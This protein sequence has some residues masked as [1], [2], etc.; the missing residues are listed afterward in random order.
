MPPL[1]IMIKP[2]S[3]NCNMR[4]LYCFYADEASQRSISSFGFMPP[5][6][7][8][9]IVRKALAK[10][11]YH[12]TFAFQGGEPTLAGLDFYKKLLALEKKYN[13][14]KISIKNIIQTNGYLIDE[15]WVRFFKKR[16]F[17]IGLSID[18]PQTIHDKYRKTP[19]K[20]GTF[21]RIMHTVSLLKKYD[22]EF[23]V[24]T[25]VTSEIA[26]QP[27]KVY[28]FYRNQ[29]LNFQQY[30]PC[31][32]PLGSPSEV[33]DYTLTSELYADFLTNMFDLWYQDFKNGRIIYI[34]FFENLLGIL[35]GQP[36]NSCTLCP[37]CQKQYVIEADGSVYPCDFY[38]LDHYK[39]GNITADTF[40][41]LD[42]KREQLRFIDSSR[43]RPITCNHC[44]WYTL[45]TSGCRRERDT[46]GNILSTNIFCSAYKQF[47]N[48]S[49]SRLL[50]LS[51]N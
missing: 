50:E 28:H 3:S 33:F 48:Y 42:L 23:N 41:S 29:N 22:V 7:L 45:C 14:K 19:F 20:A 37:E 49:F 4:C 44:K 32:N 1:T 12:C 17:F 38:A 15:T 5:D 24:L 2:A 16:D 40:A 10:A 47:F 43:I 26:K 27:S 21:Q 51:R 8:D 31:L 9:E 30:I 18:G 39:L 13:T 35:K 46:G 36:P 11:E 6:I 34:S 25:V